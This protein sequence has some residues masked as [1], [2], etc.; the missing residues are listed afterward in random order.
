MASPPA[1]RTFA[2]VVEPMLTVATPTQALPFESRTIF[3]TDFARGVSPDCGHLN[4]VATVD[5][6]YDLLSRLGSLPDEL[7]IGPH[8]VAELTGLAVATIQ[9][10]RVVG[11]PSPITGLRLLR[12]RLGDIKRWLG[13]S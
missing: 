6:N 4:G 2:V 5:R 8:E 3:S 12:W 9:Q 1:Q 13:T 11:L 7:W 10:R